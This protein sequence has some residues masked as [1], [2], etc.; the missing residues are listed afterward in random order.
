M[1]STYQL[2]GHKR[3][4]NANDFSGFEIKHLFWFLVPIIFLRK[5]F[6]LQHRL[7]PKIIDDTFFRLSKLHLN[8]GTTILAVKYKIKS[9]IVKQHRVSVFIPIF[10]E[11]KIIE[12]D[13]KLIDYIIKKIPIDYEVFIVNDASKDKTEAIGKKIEQLNK[14]VTLLN[15][16]IGPTKRENLAQSFKKAN[17][18]IVAFVDVDLITSLRFL[19]D[20]I[21]Q[22]ILNYDIATGSRY[23]AGSKIKRKPFRLIISILYNALIRLLFKTGIHDHMCGFKAFKKDVV[24]Q[25]IDEMGY[26]KSLERGIFWDTELLIRAIRHGYKIKEI[27]IWWRER[28]KT[29]LS[30]KSE[31]KALKYMFEF[32]KKLQKEKA[33]EI[34]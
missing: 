5:L 24:L 16:S 30:F 8:F 33:S 20:L 3:R 22:I 2:L 18:D 28:Q 10:N 6:G 26:D 21:G 13:V 17:G 14:K 23:T 27:P 29:A 31:T 12:R 1:V 25:L 4:Y 11:E 32:M 15:Y 7:L 34:L 9:D 19:S